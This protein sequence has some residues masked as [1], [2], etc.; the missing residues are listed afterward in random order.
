MNVLINN[1]EIYSKPDC[2]YC[3]KAKQVLRTHDIPFTEQVLGQDF[4]REIIIEKF[5]TAKTFPIVVV[6]G[7]YI[8]GYTQL[9]EQLNKLNEDNRR[10]LNE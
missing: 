10:L 4:T 6:D 7:Y 9:A 2:P 8:G 5:P 3:T 1:V